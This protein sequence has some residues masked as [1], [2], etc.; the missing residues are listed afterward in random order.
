MP[1]STLQS[2]FPAGSWSKA[3]GV[4]CSRLKHLLDCDLRARDGLA[5]SP[6]MRGISL[7]SGT[8][9]A[10]SAEAAARRAEE[11]PEDSRDPSPTKAM[12]PV[13]DGVPD[14]RAEVTRERGGTFRVELE[15]SFPTGWAGALSLGLA[16]ANVGIVSGVARRTGPRHWTTAIV[17]RPQSDGAHPETIDYLALARRRYPLGTAV[18]IELTSFEVEA[19]ERTGALLVAVT[20]VDCIGFLG[21][22]LDRLAGLALF[23]EDMTIETED[24]LARDRFAL[25]A[26]GGH[27]PSREAHQALVTMLEDLRRG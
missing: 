12:A 7:A 18:P 22:L 8:S 19:D 10:A 9:H 17:V 6:A 5:L 26:L 27:A 20:G 4:R 23:S 24:D 21:S 3:S 11:M 13:Y 16:H 15:G 25:K 1:H 2:C 14:D